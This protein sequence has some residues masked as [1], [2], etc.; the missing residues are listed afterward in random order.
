[1]ERIEQIEPMAPTA[2][3]PGR[4]TWLILGVATAVALIAAFEALAGGG[5]PAMPWDGP[6]LAIQNAL[7]GTT[8]RTVI[9]LATVAAGMM[10][11]FT[12]HGTGAKRLSLVIVA[13]GITMGAVSFLASLGI[14]GA[15]C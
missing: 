1:M 5:G 9:V 3:T 2:R 6:L 14:A 12:D 8:G 4:W 7:T 10:W 15:L 13:A 11:A